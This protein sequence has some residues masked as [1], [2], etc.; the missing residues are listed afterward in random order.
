MPSTSTSGPHHFIRTSWASASRSWQPVVAG[1][2][3]PRRSAACVS[4]TPRSSTCSR[5]TSRMSVPV[6]CAVMALIVAYA[7]RSPPRVP[8]AGPR[9]GVTSLDCAHGEH[10]DTD[11]AP[12]RR[13]AVRAGQRLPDPPRAG[14]VAGRRVGAHQPGLDLLRARDPRPRRAPG[15]APAGRGQPHASPSTRRPRRGAPSSSGSSPRRC[16]PTTAARPAGSRRRCRCSRW[17]SRA[18]FLGLLEERLAAV[19]AAARR[20][21]GA[22]RRRRPS[23]L[24]PHLPPLIGLWQAQAPHRAGLAGRHRSPAV[25]G[26][27]PVRTPATPPTGRPRPTT[28]AGPCRPTA[29]A[30]ARPSASPTDRARPTPSRVLRWLLG[31]PLRHSRQGLGP[32]SGASRAL[33]AALPLA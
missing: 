10:L 5:A 24:P 29:S 28:R 1:A 25:R 33:S 14:V 12:R 30:T 22:G 19:D 9:G 8:T 7:G 16:A 21:R 15:A 11:A 4:G 13:A 27:Q 2:A 18:V 3:A 32:D 6:T 31:R 17:S 26:R 23:V 20:G